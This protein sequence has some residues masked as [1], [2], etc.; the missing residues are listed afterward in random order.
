MFYKQNTDGTTNHYEINVTYL[1][2]FDWH[3]GTRLSRF[4]M[5]LL[6]FSGRASFYVQSILVSRNDNVG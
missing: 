3:D 5:L 4:T 1:D 2:A 6:V